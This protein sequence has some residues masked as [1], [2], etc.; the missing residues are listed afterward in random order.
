[1]FGLCLH[2]VLEY[3]ITAVLI[4][5]FYPS[6]RVK[7]GFADNSKEVKL[8][9]FFKEICLQG[10]EEGCKMKPGNENDDGKNL[11][12]AEASRR[13]LEPAGMVLRAC[14]PC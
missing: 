14:F 4:T 7:R 13:E 3:T 2:G 12:K 10:E 9:F 8:E 6:L 1:M 11:N 5:S